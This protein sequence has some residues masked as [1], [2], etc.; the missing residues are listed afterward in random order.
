[1]KGLIE[2]LVD[3]DALKNFDFNDFIEILAIIYENHPE[4]RSDIIE[5]LKRLSEYE[6]IE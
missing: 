1:M 4:K 3:T 2:L 6:K 5:V